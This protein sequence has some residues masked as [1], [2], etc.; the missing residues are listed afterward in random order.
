MASR[1]VPVRSLTTCVASTMQ[2]FIRRSARLLRSN[3][4]RDSWVTRFGVRTGD[5]QAFPV[6]AMLLG[7]QARRTRYGTVIVVPSPFAVIEKVPVLLEV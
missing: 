1:N 5:G 2:R 3:A 4:S 7:N 6:A